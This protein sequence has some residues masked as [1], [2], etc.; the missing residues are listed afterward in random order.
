MRRILYLL[1][2][3]VGLLSCWRT[4]EA[5]IEIDPE[6]AAIDSL[7]KVAQDGERGNSM[8]GFRAAQEGWRLASHKGSGV[9]R[10]RM[11]SSLLYNA[12]QL[13]SMAFFATHAPQV[14]ALY[15]SV[16]DR[17][18]LARHLR[19]MGDTHYRRM[20]H[21]P[22]QA[23]YDSS[24]AVAREV[25]AAAELAE[26]MSS[27]GSLLLDKGDPDSALVLQKGALRIMD[28]IGT[29]SLPRI[30][31]L[32]NLGYAYYWA[33]LP[34]EA[35]ASYGA[36]IEALG[37]GGDRRMRAWNHMNLGS[38]YIEKALYV[39][40]LEHLQQ[41]YD[42]HTDSEMMF[43][44]AACIYYMAYCQEHVAPP[45]EVIR[46][47]RRMIAI[48]D[49]LGFSQRSM[50]GHG[51]LGRY[52][53]DL[54]SARCVESG[55]TLEQRN[56]LALWHCRQGV[57]IARLSTMPAQLGDL[58]DGLCD[59]EHKAGALDSA[60]VHARE[61]IKIR[62]EHD[63]PA[64][65]AG[66]YEDLGMVLY[67]KGLLREAERAYLTGLQLIQG[68]IHPQNEMALHDG[69]RVLY[70]R[71][72]RYDRAYAH[73]QQVQRL[74]GSTF[75]ETQ[76][77]E[78][79]QRDLQWKFDRERLADSL[80]AAQR[81]RDIDDQRTIAELRAERADTRSLLLGGGG[82]LVVGAGTWLVVLDRRRRRERFAKET[83][84]L[85]AKALR[86]QMDPHFI[87]NSLHA[88]NGYLLANDP[89]SASD[90]LGRFARW[91]RSTLENNR[92]D[93]VPL[94]DELEA[95]RTF[96]AL[97]RARTGEK[98]EFTIVL[99]QDETL[100]R[101]RIPTMLI[102]PL[103]ENAVKHGITPKNGQG[104]I[105]LHAE[106]QVDDVVIT[107]E[108]DGVGR[109]AETTERTHRSLSSTITEERLA[110]LSGRT[111]RRA[112]MHVEDLSPGTRV[113]LRL[114]I[115]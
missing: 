43:E 31:V 22:A 28:S 5:N 55:L 15:D 47:Y 65:T 8:A 84:Q 106:E 41:A 29:D 78:L 109:N 80:K 64:R 98:F 112:T 44:A 70:A 96:L 92:Q 13:D 82:L 110:L 33:G 79:V 107:V 102:Q 36:A 20:L 62:H 103:L 100:L 37:P 34:D 9:T 16:G 57:A 113:V 6:L 63:I 88:I 77:K 73:Q 108:D 66:S 35:I 19:R 48:Y 61:A 46:S 81:V 25:G 114:P 40:A 1:L 67:S 21:P 18:L 52:L 27:T 12:V 2:L 91:M 105:R 76:R 89:R 56:V 115:C 68:H 59:A 72:G 49:S 50:T 26:T 111:G 51:Q 11:G 60:L 90:L 14:R 71:T 104:H 23:Y 45:S 24:M 3:S 69:L 30:R 53:V 85:E 17:A 95:A 99:P 75:S 54:D 94:N 83:A 4:D 10:G 7:L 87:G 42:I 58:L 93:E 86:A 38:A 39:P 32:G 74:N 97:E 101:C